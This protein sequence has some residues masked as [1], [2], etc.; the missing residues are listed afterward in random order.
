MPEPI[1]FPDSPRPI[2]SRMSFLDLVYGTL[3]HPIKTF[4]QLSAPNAHQ[5]VL[6]SA[7]ACVALTCVVD[8]VVE[9]ILSR[10]SVTSL[11]YLI[12]LKIIVG[13]IKWLWMAGML[14]AAAHVFSGKAHYETFLKLSG[15][16]LL[17][18]LLLSPVVLMVQSLQYGSWSTFGTIFLGLV[19]FLLWIWSS[20]LFV[21]ALMET[22]SMSV[23]RAFLCLLIPVMLLI[24]LFGGSVEA[25]ADFIRLCV[26]AS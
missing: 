21:L 12:P 18:E 11:S 9:Q 5:G 23:G 13:L 26:Q 19:A 6:V 15:L 20:L 24:S 2:H 7:I 14:A 22:Y 17:P 4:R 8:I 10:G 3:F 1:P 25:I 16:A